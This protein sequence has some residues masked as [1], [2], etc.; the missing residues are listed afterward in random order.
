M[1]ELAK[2]FVAWFADNA[3]TRVS[4]LGLVGCLA[5]VAALGSQVVEMAVGYT[6]A[7]SVCMAAAFIAG[8]VLA[9]LLYKS[10]NGKLAD[11]ICHLPAPIL[12]VVKKMLDEGEISCAHGDDYYVVKDLE[13][14]GIAVMSGIDCNRCYLS[15]D[16]SLALSRHPFMFW[17]ATRRLK[18]E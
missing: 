3:L 10:D 7:F 17:W 13:A 18:E 8:F 6:K 1:K 9:S 4:S 14:D 11:R 2:I 12:R 5:A 16:A 15:P